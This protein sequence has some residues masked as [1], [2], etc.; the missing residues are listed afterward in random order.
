MK[1]VN[2]Y[3]HIMFYLINLFKN[4]R[5]FFLMF[6]WSLKTI[7]PIFFKNFSNN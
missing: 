6:V 7:L 1:N 2:V 3:V 4:V 5:I